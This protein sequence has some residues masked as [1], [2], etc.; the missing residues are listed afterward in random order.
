M[1]HRIVPSW[2]GRLR[3]RLQP[4]ES[5]E[6]AKWLEAAAVP[7]LCL[8]LAWWWRPQDPFLLNLPFPW[9]WLGPVL[10]ALRYGVS[11]GLAGG[12][13]YLGAWF[14][15]RAMA[16]QAVAQAD[17][18]RDFF[19]GGGLLVLLCGQFGDTWR[20][21]F[22]RLEESSLYMTERLARLTK[23][24]LLLNLSHDKLEQEMLARP[25][26]LRDALT[27]LRQL[28]I[29][30]GAQPGE[31]PATGAMLHLLE[32]YV[33]IEAAALYAATEQDGRV[34]LGAQQG[35]V[36]EPTPLTADDALFL[37]AVEQ[38]KL[39]HI[40]R[41]E[42]S[43]E[44]ASKQLVVAPLLSSD[45]QL[46]G[47]FAVSKIPFF[48]LSVENLQMLSVLLAYYA[49]YVHNGPEIARCRTLLPTIP[50]AFAEEL[51]RM[52]RMQRKVGIGSQILIL[53]F[54]GR[55]K[56]EIPDQ[57]LQIKRGLDLYWLARRPDGVVAAAILMPFATTIGA[58]GF[59]QR[60]EGWLRQ[61]WGGDFASLQVQ[62]V[63]I[64]L[65]RED[66]LQVMARV[67]AS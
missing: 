66:P 1:G 10:V 15:A 16:A 42:V 67:M 55:M 3:Q 48:S 22:Q 46:V 9:L 54:A 25:G 4:A 7:L 11:A 6:R 5:A 26:S 37:L 18:P 51:A 32:R 64:E 30:S 65:E 59:L 28:I 47:F 21:R 38:R 39:V 17:F 2:V 43:F 35:A 29:Q 12:M 31:L 36:G 56:D 49:D 58:N 40:A 8:A 50:D 27:E 61:R 34:L 23:R 41:H 62:V 20:E 13:L 53:L 14:L 19:F 60:I 45:D 44:R 24:H 33:K 63:R 52:Q 57:L